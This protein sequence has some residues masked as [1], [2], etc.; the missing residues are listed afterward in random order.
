[1]TLS[2]I[3]MQIQIEYCITV[4]SKI[5]IIK[6]QLIKWIIQ[7]KFSIFIFKLMVL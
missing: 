7:G 1:M 5:N 6:I 2:D 4:N 3:S